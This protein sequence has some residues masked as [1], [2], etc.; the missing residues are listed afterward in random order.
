[1]FELMKMRKNG[2]CPVFEFSS[3]N[4]FSMSI[5]AFDFDAKFRVVITRKLFKKIVSFEKV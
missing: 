2:G 4:V 1:M 5:K 3:D